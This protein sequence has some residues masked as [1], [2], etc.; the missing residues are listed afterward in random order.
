MLETLISSRTRIKLLLRLF[1]NPQSTAYLRGMAEEFDESTNSIR[2][3]LNRFQEA[4][5]IVA[6]SKG[7]KKVYKANEKHPLFKDLNNIILKYV[8][9]DQ[10]IENIIHRMGDLH[11][12]YLI[13]DYAHGKDS[14]VIDLLFIGNIN[15]DYMVNFVEKSEKLINKK[16]RYLSY[17]TVEWQRMCEKEPYSGHN[18]LLWQNNKLVD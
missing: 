17:E 2:L 8:G 7:N 16:V 3:E 11:Q 9:I 14:G 15:K 5:M 4:G 12:V 1:L 6:E 13:G 18:V 10:I